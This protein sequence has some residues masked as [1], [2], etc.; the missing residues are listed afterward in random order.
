MEVELARA[1]EIRDLN[2]E[3]LVVIAADGCYDELRESVKGTNAVGAVFP[4]VVYDGKIYSDRILMLR[5]KGAKVARDC[6][7][8]FKNAG[9]ILIFADAMSERIEDMIETVYINHGNIAYLGGGA[10][11]IKGAPLFWGEEFFS[12][13]CI[14]VSLPCD[15]DVAAGHGWVET[16]VSFIA[17]R[18]EGRRIIELDWK[19]ALDAYAAALAK[20]GE[21]IEAAKKHPFGIASVGEVVIR[22]PLRFVASTIVC[23]GRVPNYS[24]LT[25][26]KGEKDS[27]IEAARRCVGEV[28]GDKLLVCDSASRVAI[29]GEDFTRELAAFR[30]AFGMLTIGEVGCK[31]RMIEF[32]N[33]SVV[34]GGIC[35]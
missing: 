20:F 11:S 31:G 12:D 7:V 35:G 3:I 17:T 30:G 8:M 23:G 14:F 27:L 16:D 24:V 5:L 10:A 18:T 13:G 1:E 2:S 34:A 6:N 33:S 25:L 26:M 28:G 22:E 4:S 21:G 32:Y 29:L 15:S 19:P 9:T